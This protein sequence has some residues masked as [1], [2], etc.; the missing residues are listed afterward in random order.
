VL[1]FFNHGKRRPHQFYG[2]RGGRE[3]DWDAFMKAID[4]IWSPIGYDP[5]PMLESFPFDI[6]IDPTNNIIPIH[7]SLSKV[8]F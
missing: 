8:S 4:R 5:T 7:P 2:Q 3:T 6:P 1:E